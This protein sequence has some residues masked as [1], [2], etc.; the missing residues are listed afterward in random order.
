MLLPPATDHFGKQQ[1]HLEIR[2]HN[3]NYYNYTLRKVNF[4]SCKKLKKWSWKMGRSCEK[5]P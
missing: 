1:Y 3:I 4:M 5:M 2:R